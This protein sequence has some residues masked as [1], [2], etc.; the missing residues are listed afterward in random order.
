MSDQALSKLRVIDLSHY[1]AGPYCTKLLAGFGAEVVKIEPPKTGDKMRGVGPFFEDKEGLD[2]SIPFL[3]LNTGKKSLTL[4][5]KSRE[6]ADLFKKLVKDAD[7]VV[8][9]F[10]PS[11]LKGLGLDYPALKKI[12]PRLVMASISN[13]GQTGPYRDFEAE[14][15]EAYAMCGAM[16]ATGLADKPP[17][18]CGPAVSQYSAAMCAYFGILMA[19]FARKTGGTG[20]HIDVS[21]M[22]CGIDQVEN[23]VT[24]YLQLGKGSKRGA[25]M[26]SPWGLYRCK[27]GY[28]AVIGAPFRHWTKGAGMFQE[29]QL[30]DP[31]YHHVRDRVQHRKEIDALLQPWLDK[32][33]RK[34]IFE[35]A[36]KRRLAFG[37]LLTF[38]EVAAS[39]QHKARQF[40]VDV[41]HPVVGRQKYAD[42]PFKMARTPWKTTRA[43]LLGEHNKEVLSGL[44]GLPEKEL[45][46]LQAEGVIG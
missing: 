23:R 41:E 15:I 14:E 3:W 25:H 10:S 27:D 16:Y 22:E 24:N 35:E 40:F 38:D 12:N 8:E 31:K 46:R 6:G 2:R 42:A 37:S 29:P 7:V 9:N 13:F 33:T 39:P 20:Q 44:L 11:V 4:N 36:T 19:L 28:E 45:A 30:L 17:L 32:H 43:P 21:I 26:Y 34:E 1:M 18:S 5:L